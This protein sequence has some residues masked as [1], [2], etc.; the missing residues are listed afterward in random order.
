MAPQWDEVVSIPLRLAE[1][2]YKNPGS[3]HQVVR[4]DLIPASPPSVQ[5]H[6]EDNNNNV[7][8]GLSQHH[9]T[10]YYGFEYPHTLIQYS[11]R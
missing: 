8:T 7:T 11:S 4:A 3:P 2:V 1:L 9:V 5:P 6:S 10:C